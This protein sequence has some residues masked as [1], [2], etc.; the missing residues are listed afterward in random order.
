VDL[1]TEEG[2]NEEGF[3]NVSRSIVEEQIGTKLMV[4]AAAAAAGKKSSVHYDTYET[5]TINNVVNALSVAMGINIEP[6]KEFI[7]N[8]VVYLLSNK[9]ESEHDYTKQVR[10]R[11]EA[12][13]KM[14]SYRD[15]YNTSLLYFTFGMYLVAVQ[16]SMPSVKTRKTHPG[17]IRSF[18]GY[19]LD[20][21]GGDMSSVTYLGCV[22]YDVRGTGEPWNVLKGKKRDVIIQ[23]IKAYMDEM[24]L[25][26]PAVI[27]HIQ[28]KNVYLLTTPAG[29]IP[30]EHSLSQWIHFLP[31]LVPFVLKKENV[32]NITSDFKK[33]FLH[34]VKVGSPVQREKIRVFQS[35]MFFFS[36]GVI[37]NIERIVDKKE[38]L[39]RSMSGEPFLENACCN[40]SP[41]DITLAY[42]SQQ[43]P[44]IMEYNTYVAQL[45]NI[46]EDVR[47]YSKSGI[48]CS[49]INTKNKYPSIVSEFGEKTVYMAFLSFCHFNK[50]LPI[51]SYLLPICDNKPANMLLQ[52]GDSNDRLIQRMKEAGKKYTNENLLQLLQA[53]GRHNIR[54][55]QL[56]QPMP[57]AVGVFLQH[58]EN[59]PLQDAEMEPFCHRMRTAL[60]TFQIAT[61]QTTAEVRAVNNYL[62]EK[63]EDLR[64]DILDFIQKNAAA[65]VNK[66]TLTK[67]INIIQQLSQE[68]PEGGGQGLYSRLAF[69]KNVIHAVARVFPAMI[70]NNVDYKK[71]RIPH[72]YGF[73]RA[74]EANLT[75][76]IQD[77][78]EGLSPFYGSAELDPLLSSVQTSLSFLVQLSEVTPCF[79]DITK[80]DTVLHPVINEYT[81]KKMFE[82]YLLQCFMRYIQLT[83]QVSMYKTNATNTKTRTKKTK[84]K[85]KRV[86]K[87][88]FIPDEEEQ[89]ED[90]KNAL[91]LHGNQ[92]AL[93]EKTV[94][95]FIAYLEIV[96]QEKKTVDVSY[97][98]IQQNVFKLKQREKNLI[99]DKLKRMNEEEREMDT[100]MKIVKLGVYSKGMQ[101]GLTVLDKD[102]YD[103]EEDFR[104]E[105]INAERNIRR[106]GDLEDTVEVEDALVEEYLE[107]QRANQEIEDEVYDMEYINDDYMDGNF[108]GTG[109]PEE[110]YDD[111][112]DYDS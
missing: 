57:S 19:P 23:K 104:T 54:P 100:M 39:R 70:V 51:P 105:M 107:E 109:A 73:S 2:Y 58:L 66:K 82:F 41:Q 13:K 97:E 61:A 28:E 27:Q 33:A 86:K 12:G 87:S 47:W 44:E 94:D 34:D 81:G 46:L 67:T 85:T 89:E 75:K 49:T 14:L 72:H 38:V 43:S 26:L 20:G 3:K 69:Y 88:D 9:L 63:I 96:Y 42:F 52:P 79:T 1:D 98:T 59:A 74:H 93:K 30:S 99:T 62:V 108:D 5:K 71:L 76:Y 48:F 68:E 16:T 56:N 15:F 65:N 22:V 4:E 106:K 84:A 102:Y 50:V 40:S 7:M 80:G 101:K 77:Y 24:V 25:P 60:D 10:E 92:R 21:Q 11:A 18:T 8:G 103:E 17:C 31:P 83:N 29:D 90:E 6:Q 37:A 36:L 110:E 112:G 111:Y 55:M 78:Y 45:G 64:E 91:L 32:M 53:V 95:L 35:K